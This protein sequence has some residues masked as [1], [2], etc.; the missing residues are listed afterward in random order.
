[1]PAKIVVEP[2]ERSLP[3]SVAYRS[4]RITSFRKELDVPEDA[5]TPLDK[6]A[7][8][9]AEQ[10]ADLDQQEATLRARYDMPA[11]DRPGEREARILAAKRANGIPTG[12]EVEQARADLAKPGGDFRTADQAAKSMQ[13]PPIADA[14]RTGAPGTIQAREVGPRNTPPPSAMRDVSDGTTDELRRLAG[15]IHAAGGT[16]EFQPP[17]T[18]A[19]ADAIIPKLRA[20]LFDLEKANQPART[21][22]REPGLVKPDGVA[23][24]PGHQVAAWERKCGHPAHGRDPLSIGAQEWNAS[25]AA[26]GRP[27]CGAHLAEAR[28]G[29]R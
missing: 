27:L 3:T 10:L 16:V 15:A 24:K 22:T 11:P 4:E 14:P 29:G 12:S 2:M 23:F 8:V 18:Q 5:P 9:R 25:M 28:K 20:Q 17:A 19:Q 7:K 21:V 13:V 1:M 26:A 6:I